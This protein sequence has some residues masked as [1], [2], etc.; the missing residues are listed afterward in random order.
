MAKFMT[1]DPWSKIIS[2]NGIPGDELV[3]GLQKSIR[4][5]LEREASMIA[6][7]MYITSLQFEEKLWRRLQAISVEDV[8][9]GNLEAPN[10]IHTLNQMRQNFPYTDG[11]RPIFFIHAIRVLCQSKKDRSS[12]HLKN[13]IIKQ[14]EQGVTPEIPDYAYDMHT[15][16]GIEMG[17]DFKHFLE[18]ASKVENELNVTNTYKEELLKLLDKLDDKEPK[19]GS[20]RYNL[21]QM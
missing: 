3:S 5:G 1:Y 16:K 9:Y 19:E 21:W 7:E 15:Q 17:R 6:Y 8:G 20:F 18:H 14:F 2:R 10:L 13:I 4:R 11:D 12:D